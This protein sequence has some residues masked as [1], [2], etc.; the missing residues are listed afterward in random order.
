MKTKKYIVA[1]G[2]SLSVALILIFTLKT[3]VSPI[4]TTTYWKDHNSWAIE[5]FQEQEGE[6]LEKVE[7][8]SASDP[9]FKSFTEYMEKSW[10]KHSS[11]IYFHDHV[12]FHRNTYPLK[13]NHIESVSFAYASQKDSEEQIPVSI[14]IKTYK[15]IN[16]KEES[17]SDSIPAS[18]LLPRYLDDTT[19]KGSLLRFM[20]KFQYQWISQNS[21]KYEL[22]TR[23]IPHPEVSKEI[24]SEYLRWSK[25][26]FFLDKK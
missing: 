7:L 9:R 2:I 21:K 23:V 5:E 20:S 10:N 15:P 14:K 16:A 4:P 11:T 12:I 13:M 25:D 22:H 3:L 1:L 17:F 26:V 8:I 19:L 18:L 6:K 24:W